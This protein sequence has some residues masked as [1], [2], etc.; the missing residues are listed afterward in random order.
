MRADVVVFDPKT[1]RDTS[2][3]EDPH[4]FAE[5]ISNVIVNGGLVLH[6][7]KMT[8]ALPGKVLRRGLQ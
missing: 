5:G 4:H 3:Y 2:T 8:G 7:G 6:D 1:I